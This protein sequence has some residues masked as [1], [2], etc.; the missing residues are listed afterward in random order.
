MHCPTGNWQPHYAVLSCSYSHFRARQPQER[1]ARLLCQNY[2]QMNAEHGSQQAQA[3]LSDMAL[4]L[5]QTN[6]KLYLLLDFINGGHLFFQLY[7]QVRACCKAL[8]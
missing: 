8:C 4:C 7:R 1:L 5:L 3:N 2:K 6:S